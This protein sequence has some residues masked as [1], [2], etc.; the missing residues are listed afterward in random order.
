MQLKRWNS[1]IAST[2][3][4]TACVTGVA[5]ASSIPQGTPSGAQQRPAAT[6]VKDGWITMKI[7]SQFIPEDALDNSDIDV[8][9]LNGVVTLTGI[10]ASDAGKARALAIAKAT[11][12]VKSVSD[13][14]RVAA[15]GASDA[16][17]AATSAGRRVNDGWITSK[18]YA[19]F[20]NE[21]PLEDSD[22]DVDVTAGVATLN[23]TVMSEAGRTRA[24]AIAKATDGVKSVKDNLKVTA[25]KQ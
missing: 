23:G 5:T 18:I 24:M 16:A 19:D 8:E 3:L 4:A 22:I 15:E 21:K 25:R 14:M 17:K 7:H 6:A 1:V 12:G 10:V 9:T 11:D 13:K 20:L 2:F